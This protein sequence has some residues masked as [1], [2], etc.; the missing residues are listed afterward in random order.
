MTALMLTMSFGNRA[1]D[2]A[3]AIVCLAARAL[4]RH[5]S[6]RRAGGGQGTKDATRLMREALAAQCVPPSNTARRQSQVRAIGEN[7]NWPV[8]RHFPKGSA[9]EAVIRH[10]AN[11]VTKGPNYRP[12]QKLSHDRHAE[13]FIR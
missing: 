2:Q 1:R 11:G 3:M 5:G 13:P 12:G 7:T 6:W 4:G 8:R 10:E 9:L